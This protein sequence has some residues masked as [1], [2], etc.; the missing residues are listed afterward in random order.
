MAHHLIF[1]SFASIAFGF[2][3]SRPVSGRICLDRGLL[4]SLRMCLWDSLAR[5]PFK[6]KRLASIPPTVLLAS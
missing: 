6:G 2:L 4:A 5:H 3:T 1:Q